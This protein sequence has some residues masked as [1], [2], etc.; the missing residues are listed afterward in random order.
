MRYEWLKEVID[1]RELML[2]RRLIAKLAML[3]LPDVNVQE[4]NTLCC[5]GCKISASSRL[6]KTGSIKMIE[7]TR[8]MIV[9]C[10]V[11]QL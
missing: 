2:A 9:S 1:L 7:S 11:H 4:L 10:L 6:V 5:I 3:S 8:A